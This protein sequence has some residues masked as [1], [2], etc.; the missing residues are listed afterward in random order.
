MP[1]SGAICALGPAAA[2][3]PKPLLCFVSASCQPGAASSRGR[4]GSASSWELGS[5]SLDADPLP[6]AANYRVSAPARLLP[7]AGEE[8]TAHPEGIPS[9]A[10]K[11]PPP[12]P[13]GSAPWFYSR[14]RRLPPGGT[15]T[16]H[17]PSRIPGDTLFRSLLPVIR[18]KSKTVRVKG[19]YLSVVA[20][21]QFNELAQRG[22]SSSLFRF[23]WKPFSYP[24]CEN[25]QVHNKS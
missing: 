22:D 23:W 19:I 25:F 15:T 3:S 2:P 9:A 13:S 8:E 18:L 21:R 16:I 11:P 17:C 10:L 14:G 20:I 7:A 5:L 4:P 1:G 6:D 24:S 12:T